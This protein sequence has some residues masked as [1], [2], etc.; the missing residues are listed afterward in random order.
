[1][2]DGVRTGAD[3]IHQCDVLVVGSGAAEAISEIARERHRQ[4]RRGQAD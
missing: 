3:T 1:V 4:Q 2:A